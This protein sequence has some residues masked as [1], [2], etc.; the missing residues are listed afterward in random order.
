[1]ACYRTSN[2][3]TT[4]SAIKTTNLITIFSFY[5]R[6]LAMAENKEINSV[7]RKLR[8]I[9]AGLIMGQVFFLAIVLYLTLTAKL[10]FL[11]STSHQLGEVLLLVM[12]CLAIVEFFVGRVIINGRIH[13]IKTD[14][15][16]YQK[17]ILAEPVFII[18]WGLIEGIG[19]FSIIILLISGILWITV[20]SALLIMVLLYFQPSAA[21]IGNILR[22]TQHETDHLYAL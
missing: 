22:L 10:T 16:L 15:P 21:R 3:E 9:H 8:I 13:E 6:F 14:L 5:Q 18:I 19:L 11:G 4:K 12:A 20:I 7:I 2:A 1:V 17:L